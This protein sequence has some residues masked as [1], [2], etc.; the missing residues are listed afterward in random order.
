MVI[1]KYCL[2]LDGVLYTV[3]DLVGH[4]FCLEVYQTAGVF[5]VFED[6]NHGV[7][8]P[9]ALIAGVITAGTARSSRPLTAPTGFTK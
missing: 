1:L 5:P 2:F 7:G 9:F 3:L 6:M 8:R 4:L